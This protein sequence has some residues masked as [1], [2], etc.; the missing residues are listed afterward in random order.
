MK[1]D[2]G[3][4]KDAQRRQ[5][6]Q[7]DKA[8][9]KAARTA[10]KAVAKDATLSDDAKAARADVA[11]HRGQSRQRAW[12]L[13]LALDRQAALSFLEGLVREAE[14]KKK[15]ELAAMLLHSGDASHHDA[16][17]AGRLG[18]VSLFDDAPHAFV[19]A[20][21]RV[22]ARAQDARGPPTS[23]AL[24][25][26]AL[27]LGL[28]SNA[29]VKAPLDRAVAHVLPGVV[30]TL[31]D[32]GALRGAPPPGLVLR[33]ALLLLMTRPSALWTRRDVVS[34]A[35]ADLGDADID[36]AGEGIGVGHAVVLAGVAHGVD[37]SV[38]RDDGLDE[39]RVEAAAAWLL[40]R[41]GRTAAMTGM[42]LPQSAEQCSPRVRR[43]LWRAVF[44]DD[45][46][47]AA[48]R[49]RAAQSLWL[50][51]GPL[52]VHTLLL[53]PL[54]AAIVL[55]DVLSACEIDELEELLSTNIA[56]VAF[57]DA[58]LSSRHVRH[59]V[60]TRAM[61]AVVDD[62]PVG[63]GYAL[64]RSEDSAAV[65]DGEAI[66]ERAS[67]DI[68]A[69][70][71]VG[72]LADLEAVAIVRNAWLNHRDERLRASLGHTVGGVDP[73]FSLAILRALIKRGDASAVDADHA[74]A[75]IIRRFSLA[76]R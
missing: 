75:R 42:G 47:A 22:V 71:V 45:G 74:V 21:A 29:L 66:V 76:T 43:C 23:K 5:K 20:A 9:K 16:A 35:A 37:A 8:E 69:G 60:V 25:T 3:Q 56:E 48:D 55:S 7:A 67:A 34:S 40:T 51:D 44:L 62:D 30:T 63:V 14:G 11:K 15:S 70:V 49:G 31:I 73:V 2:P 12:S 46:A 52:A 39:A 6:L 18:D 68:A 65:M 50:R 32:L 1:P 59:P 17:V 13:L 33:L 53:R 28:M 64:A 24:H 19:D 36:H 61:R 26:T 41:P 4:R 38:S 27:R 58:L 57:R 54:A 10:A 72:A